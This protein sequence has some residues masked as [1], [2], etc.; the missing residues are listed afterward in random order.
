MLFSI[1]PKKRRLVTNFINHTLIFCVNQG[2]IIF[3]RIVK[4]KKKNKKQ[5]PY[6]PN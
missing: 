6:R 1:I 5:N 4:K 3:L 2:M